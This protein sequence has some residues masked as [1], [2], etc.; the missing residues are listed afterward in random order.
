MKKVLY[1][2]IMI[3]GCLQLH[4][5]SNHVMQVS[6][7]VVVS[8]SLYPVPFVTVYRSSDHRG[9]YSDYSGYFTLPMQAGDTL[10]FL[11]TGLVRSSYIIP[12][13]TTQSHISIVQWM[14]EDTS[15]TLPT[16]TIMPYPAPH[17]LTKELL[18]LDLPGDRYVKFSRGSESASEYDG[19]YEVADRGAEIEQATLTA[20]TSGGGIVSGGNLLD[21]SAWK[22][23]MRAVKRGK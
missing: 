10:N 18:A 22:N 13:D 8:D 1:L 11:C 5:Q 20:R 3:F 17:L 16:V 4:A 7:I 14:E 23:F 12:N 9:T 15:Y 2:S 19:L 21:P 6:G